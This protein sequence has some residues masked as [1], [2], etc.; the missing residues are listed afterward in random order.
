SGMDAI[1]R[2]FQHG[3]TI[4]RAIGDIGFYGAGG[5]KA[6][7][8]MASHVQIWTLRDGMVQHDSVEWKKWMAARSFTELGVSDDWKRSSLFNTPEELSM[9]GHGTFIKLHLSPRRR[10]HAHHVIAQLSK[11][12]ST[13][14]RRGKRITW[15]NVRRNE[16]LDEKQLSDLFLPPAENAKT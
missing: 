7:L 15:I 5:T 13:G 6:I 12:Y 16:V 10:F 1:G 8:W 14:L 9:R 2:L 11:T 4:G 3:N